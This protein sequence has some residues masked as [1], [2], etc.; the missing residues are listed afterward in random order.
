[1][2]KDSHYLFEMKRGCTAA[3]QPDPISSTLFPFP[4][5]VL[6]LARAFP[7]PRPHKLVPTSGPLHLPFPRLDLPPPDLPMA[8]SSH[9]L[10]LLS[11]EEKSTLIIPSCHFLQYYAIFFLL[12]ADHCLKLSFTSVFCLP[13]CARM[14]ASSQRA[15]C[16]Y[17]SLM[18]ICIRRSIKSIW[19]GLP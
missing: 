5:A 12:R 18:P 19:R 13:T 4:L 10:G 11:K 15:L 3:Q 9:H 6:Q 1:M 16:P 14:C 8:D 7:A 2:L 17:G